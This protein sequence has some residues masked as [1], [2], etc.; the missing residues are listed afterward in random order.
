MVKVKK[1]VNLNTLVGDDARGRQ[2]SVECAGKVKVHFSGERIVAAIVR[3]MK[4]SDCHYVVGCSAWFTN[5]KIIKAM[6]ALKGVAM[7][8]TLDRTAVTESNKRKYRTLPLL[9]NAKSAIQ[10][11]G[12]RGNKWTKS[13]MHHKFLV[14]MNEKQEAVAVSNGSFNLTNSATRH[15]ENVVFHEDSQVACIFKE[16]F[17]R[18]FA[19][20]KPLK[21]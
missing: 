18:L 20:S 16:E 10:T 15:L 21:L 17:L 8:V 11:I 19:I 7:I 4:R 12:T 9:N 2:A 5:E 6:S 14:F 1:K 13:L 3:R